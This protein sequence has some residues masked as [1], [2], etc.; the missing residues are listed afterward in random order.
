[1][2]SNVLNSADPQV[3]SHLYSTFH[4]GLCHSELKFHPLTHQGGGSPTHA[5]GEGT[6]SSWDYLN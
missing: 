2:N 1:M 5:S 4:I 6:A 3:S